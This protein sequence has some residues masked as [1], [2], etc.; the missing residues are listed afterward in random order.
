MTVPATVSTSSCGAASAAKCAEASAPAAH[1]TG[2]PIGS[3][4]SIA[5]GMDATQMSMNNLKEGTPPLTARMWKDPI[6]IA[7]IW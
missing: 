6:V 7:M 1:T 3:P 2:S 4:S 5:Y